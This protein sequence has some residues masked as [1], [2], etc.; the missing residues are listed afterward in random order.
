MRDIKSR[1]RRID[2]GAWIYGSYVKAYDTIN[3]YIIESGDHRFILVSSETVGQYTGLKDKTGVEIYE[4]DRI[5]TVSVDGTRLSTFIIEWDED[6][7]RFVM[8][9][10]HDMERFHLNAGLSI[11]K[12]VIGNIHEQE[13]HT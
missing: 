10:E 1:G 13:S 12:E 3:P 9:R 2:T 7:V 8:I 5:Q 11:N 4:G 6:Y